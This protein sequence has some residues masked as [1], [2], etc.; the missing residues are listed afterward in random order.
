MVQSDVLCPFIIWTVNR[1][2][3]IFVVQKLKLL[4]V[5]HI[6]DRLDTARTMMFGQLARNYIQTRS[7]IG[8]P[9]GSLCDH[10]S[11]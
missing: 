10:T 7:I 2:P 4:P 1:K 9:N 5:G 8:Q 11:I 3:M 6:C